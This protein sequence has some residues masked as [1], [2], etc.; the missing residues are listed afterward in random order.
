MKFNFKKIAPILA[1]AV[2]LGSTIGFASVAADLGSYPSPFVKGGVADVTVIYGSDGMAIDMEAAALL[3]GDLASELAEQT[4]EGGGVPIT[5]GESIDVS[6]GSRRLYFG[7]ALN[8]ARSDKITKGYLPTILADGKA[9]D[10]AGISYPYTQTVK[11]NAIGIGY[12]KSSETIDP[13]MLLGTGTTAYNGLYNYTVSFDKDIDINSSDV[14]GYTTLKLQGVDY[15]IGPTS[16]STSLV[17]YGAGTVITATEGTEQTVTI[18]GTEHTIL[19]DAASG[20]SAYLV[21]DGVKKTT[22]QGSSYS[23]IGD[24]VVYIKT[25]FPAAVAGKLSWAELVLGTKKLTLGNNAAVTYL[26]E[27]TTTTMDYTMVSITAG[28]TVTAGSVQQI[29]GFTIAQASPTSGH[30]YVAVGESY[31]DRVFGGLKVDFS[32]L[33][34]ALDSTARDKVVIEADGCADVAITFTTA[35]SGKEFSTTYAKD[36]DITCSSNAVAGI[37]ANSVN[38]TIHVVENET[39]DIGDWFVINANDEGTIVQLKTVGLGS[40]VNDVTTFQDVITGT[41]YSIT[42]GT[43]N[44]STTANIAGNLYNIRVGNPTNAEDVNVAITWGDAALAWADTTTMNTTQITYGSQL[45]VFPRIKLKNGGWLAFMQNTTVYNSSIVPLYS[46]PGPELLSTYQ[47]GKAIAATDFGVGDDTNYTIAGNITYALESAAENASAKIVGINTTGKSYG[48]LATGLSC[49]F[50]KGPAVLLVEE[51]QVGMGYT[52]GNAVCVPLT[53]T[54]ISYTVLAVGQPRFTESNAEAVGITWPAKV[55]ENSHLTSQ[56]DKYGTFVEYSKKAGSAYKATI[57]YPDEQMVANIFLGEVAAAV[58]VTE[59]TEVQKLGDVVLSD[60]E[61]A[62]IKPQTNLI[63]VGDAAV[64]KV[65]FELVKDEATTAGLTYPVYGE[66]LT[67]LY[68]YG[69]DQAI[70]KLF[71]SPYLGTKIAMLVA[72][73]EG[74]DTVAAAKQLIDKTTTLVDLNEKVIAK[75]VDYT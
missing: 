20:T 22:A 52:D 23:F 67:T 33:T 72:G 31:T 36:R 73:W 46:L 26:K 53:T 37:L 19:L 9:T 35:L 25:V 1:S 4:A 38:K 54:S 55:G 32:A 10:L 62:T 61:A 64:N 59:P 24:L 66:G 50:E 49:S 44:Y 42:T 3:T 70:V 7:D 51:K 30:D 57:L 15:L 27:G 12:N 58:I 34:P 17:L 18:G 75:G 63:V 39:G 65:A 47:T 2:L 28:A 48:N 11:L 43:N 14:F 45:T 21:V 56:I 68:G 8:T 71:T 16:S 60:T 13:I 5:T 41:T 29:K 69:A 74:P 6:L 40:S